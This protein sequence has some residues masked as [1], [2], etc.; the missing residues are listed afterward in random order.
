M[1]VQSQIEVCVESVD[2][3][4]AAQTAGAHRVE[5]CTSLL[6]GGLTPSYGLIA[7]TRSALQIGLHVMIRPRGGDFLY[8]EAEYAVMQQDLVMAKE[9]GADGVVF[10]MLQ[11]NGTL[12]SAR[13]QP[14][15]ALARPMTVT[16]HRAFD[17]AADPFAALAELMRLQADILLTS[18]QQPTAS[19]GSALLRELAQVAGS[20]IRIM[21]G[22]GINEE[23][24]LGIRK[25]TAV[26]EFHVSAR[27]QVDSRMLFK[28]QRI[29]MSTSAHTS[30]YTRLATDAGRIR[31]IQRLLDSP[32]G[33]V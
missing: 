28:N 1:A 13:L 21:A 11:R 16:F 14:L 25:I 17:V 2:G 12:D 26:R 22:G 10:G 27:S 24:I 5:L 29:A 19:E 6:E 32:T 33:N 7:A 23:N 9:L 18:G 3:A 20:R 15:I 4:L 8:S 30:E 31:A